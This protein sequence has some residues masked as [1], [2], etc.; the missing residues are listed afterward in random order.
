MQF[1][2]PSWE[3]SMLELGLSSDE[4][5]PISLKTSRYFQSNSV[6]LPSHNSYGNT[7]LIS[8]FPPSSVQESPNYNTHWK[9][10]SAHWFPYSSNGNPEP[11]ET[12]AG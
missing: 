4:K 3:T 10:K 6:L 8:I 2:E 5:S 12:N 11:F 1:S 7:Q 9:Y